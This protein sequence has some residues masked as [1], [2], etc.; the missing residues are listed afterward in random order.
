TTPSP[1]A[2][3]TD[4]E[5]RVVPHGRGGALAAYATELPDQLARGRVVGPHFLVPRGHQLRPCLIPPEERR[6]PGR[7]FLPAHAPE[8]FARLLFERHQERVLL[9]VALQEQPVVVEHRRAARALT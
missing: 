1:S 6:R 9:V 5:H 8:F 2:A 3:H 4:V 7:P